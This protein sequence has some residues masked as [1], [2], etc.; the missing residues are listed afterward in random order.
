MTSR[1][2]NKGKNTCANYNY[3][4]NKLEKKLFSL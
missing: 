2:N 1:W 4:C 3:W